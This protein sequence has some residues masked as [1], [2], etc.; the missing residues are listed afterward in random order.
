MPTVLNPTDVGPQVRGTLLS[1]PFPGHT[2]LLWPSS[3]CKLLLSSLA[4]KYWCLLRLK[5]WPSG[6]QSRCQSSFSQRRDSTHC[7]F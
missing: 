6:V 7:G 1:T 3:R 2:L 5:A 4:I